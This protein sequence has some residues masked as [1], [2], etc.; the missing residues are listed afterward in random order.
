[1]P[2][3]RYFLVHGSQIIELNSDSYIVP[4]DDFG[5]RP[6]ADELFNAADNPGLAVIPVIEQLE[7]R[8]SEQGLL[9]DADGAPFPEEVQ[10]AFRTRC[11]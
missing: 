3:V 4:V 6:T 8:E 5:P 2:R 7:W 9:E 1:M 11:G 10:Q